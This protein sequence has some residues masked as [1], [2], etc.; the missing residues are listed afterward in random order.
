MTLDG[1]M[2]TTATLVALPGPND[3]AYNVTLY[4]VQEL[5]SVS[6]TLD[7]ALV[8][9]KPTSGSPVGSMIRFDSALV[10]DTGSSVVSPSASGAGGATSTPSSG[11]GSMGS[12]QCAV[13]RLIQTPMS[14]F[15]LAA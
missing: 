14:D 3:F 11:D 1:N 5:L 15:S 2:S 10:N 7:V 13:L 12:S 6:H 9:Y 8:G 4:N